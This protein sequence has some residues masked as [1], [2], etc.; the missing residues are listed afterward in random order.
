VEGALSL[1]ELGILEAVPL[2][3]QRPEGLG[4]HREPLDEDR[5]LALARGPD[6]AG[7]TDDVA[8]IHLG[9]QLATGPGRCPG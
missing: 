8:E 9:Q 3:G 1:L 7:R 4:E 6:T 2:L 5:Q